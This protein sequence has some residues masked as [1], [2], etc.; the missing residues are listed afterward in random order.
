MPAAVETERKA[1]TEA[2]L[3]ALPEAGYIHEVVNGELVMSPKN[4]WVHGDLCV[5]LIVALA[6]FTRE[7]RLGAVFDSSTGFWMANR[8]CRAPDISFICKARLR[9]LKRDQPAFFQGAPD[10]A[11]EV[12]SPSM[13]RRDL[14]ERLRDFFSS[15]CKLAW[16]IDPEA[17]LVEICHS[18]TQ[19]R[20]LGPGGSLDGEELLPGFQYPIADLFKEWEW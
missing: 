13:T 11:V 8:N 2:E 12:L 17:K 3:A 18:P 16:V 4:N 1:W 5:R 15:G 19:R 20:L 9:G 10:L 7:Q 14:D 6:T